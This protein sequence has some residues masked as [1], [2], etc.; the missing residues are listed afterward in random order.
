MSKVPERRKCFSKKSEIHF[1]KKLGDKECFDK[2]PLKRL[3]DIEQSGDQ[4]EP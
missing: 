1:F 2:F 3:K 4:A